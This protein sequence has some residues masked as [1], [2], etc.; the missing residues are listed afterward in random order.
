M[1]WAVQNAVF[2][3]LAE[4]AEVSKLSKEER[5]KIA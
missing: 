3:R 2:R 5:L 1:P 4:V